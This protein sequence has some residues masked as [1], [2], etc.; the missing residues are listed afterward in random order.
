MKNLLTCN[1]KRFLAVSSIPF[2]VNKINQAK[3]KDYIYTNNKYIHNIFYSSKLSCITENEFNTYIKENRFNINS[4][5]LEDIIDYQDVKSLEYAYENMSKT[6]EYAEYFK[7]KSLQKIPGYDYNPIEININLGSSTKIR[8]RS[9]NQYSTFDI[10]NKSN[11]PKDFSVSKYFNKILVYRIGS[12]FYSTSSICGYCYKDLG[13]GVFLGEKISCSYCNSEYS[14]KTGNCETGPNIKNLASFKVG[15]KDD[16]IIIRLPKKRLPLFKHHLETNSNKKMDPRHY[17]IIGETE[18]TTGALH[19]LKQCFNGDI[20]VIRNNK[21]NNYL[22][23]NKLK[24]SLF[25]L[26]NIN[27]SYMFF[28]IYDYYNKNIKL[29]IPK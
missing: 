24:S 21:D 6:Q 4:S 25:P 13:D 27:D 16:N 1:Y 3:Y 22:N 17:V 20:T 19:V 9:F 11:T 12:Q 18:T 10:Y 14:I 29:N 15:L 26:A 28:D 8:N 23:N 5:E 7:E 2:I